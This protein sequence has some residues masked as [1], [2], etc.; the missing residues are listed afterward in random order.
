[1]LQIVLPWDSQFGLMKRALDVPGIALPRLSTQ[2]HTEP[3]HWV[4]S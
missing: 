4:G 2:R 1:M 3:A